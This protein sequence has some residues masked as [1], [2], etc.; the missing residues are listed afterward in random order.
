MRIL[1]R[2][3]R[4]SLLWIYFGVDAATFIYLSFFDGYVYTWWN[5]LI[6]VPINIFLGTIW[7]IY[8]LLLRPLIDN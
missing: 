3:L 6:V 4:G 1:P 5:W 8:W 7:P 2:F